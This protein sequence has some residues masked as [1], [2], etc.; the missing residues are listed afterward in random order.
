[1]PLALKVLW[2]ENSWFWNILCSICTWPT[3]ITLP[4]RAGTFSTNKFFILLHLVENSFSCNSIIVGHH[5][6]AKFCTCYGNV[7]IV[8]CAK[9]HSDQ[10]ITTKMRVKSMFY[11][12]WITV[13]NSFVKCVS[14]QYPMINAFYHGCLTRYVKLRVVHAPGMPGTFS[15]PPISKET[16][17][18]R[19]RHASRHVRHAKPWRRGKRFRHSRRM[20]NPQFYV[21]DKRPIAGTCRCFTYSW[22]GVATSTA[23]MIS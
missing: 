1:M 17:G 11:R 14:D 3:H 4:C 20:R 22:T 10:F 21:S 2:K 5:V 8:S 15:L 13:K 7:A 12:I 19:S 16:A 23:A 9:F 6:A 18:L